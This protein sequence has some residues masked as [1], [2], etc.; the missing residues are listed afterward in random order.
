MPVLEAGCDIIPMLYNE[1][2]FGCTKKEQFL[3]SLLLVLLCHFA[4][5]G[6]SFEANTRTGRRCTLMLDNRIKFNVLCSKDKTTTEKEQY[7]TK[8]YTKS[9]TSAVDSV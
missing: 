4:F 9:S 3:H 6:T 5:S 1:L 2:Y 7:T 8:E